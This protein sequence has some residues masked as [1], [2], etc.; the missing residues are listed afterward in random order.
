MCFG[1]QKCLLCLFLY[2]IIFFLKSTLVAHDVKS[3][4]GA[5]SCL[6]RPLTTAG[7]LIYNRVPQCASAAFRINVKNLGVAASFDAAG[8][9]IDYLFSAK[10]YPDFWITDIEQKIKEAINKS[11]TYAAI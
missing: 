8:Y 3:A 1:G 11:F 2:S 6:G 9:K 10:Q 4:L 5:R 7:L